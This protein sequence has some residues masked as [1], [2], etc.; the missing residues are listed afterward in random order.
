MDQNCPIVIIMYFAVTLRIYY[1][2]KLFKKLWWGRI[3]SYF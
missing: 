1:I 3:N 2:N